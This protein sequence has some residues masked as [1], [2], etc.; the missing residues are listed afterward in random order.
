MKLSRFFTLLPS[1]NLFQ[2]PL[3]SSA[4]HS[5][6][7]ISASVIGPNTV[8]PSTPSLP[9]ALDSLQSHFFDT[10]A[11]TWPSAIDW[12]AAVISTLTAAALRTELRSSNNKAFNKQ[13]FERHFK[14]FLLS[15]DGQNARSIKLQAFDDILWVALNWVEGIRLLDELE[16]SPLR[17]SLSY[18]YDYWRARMLSR[19]REFWILAKNGWSTDLC[20]GGM[21]WSPWLEPYK[22]AIT[23]ELWISAS[24]SLFLYSPPPGSENHDAAY[25]DA[26]VQGYEWLRASH[27]TNNNGLYTDGFHISQLLVPDAPLPL[28][29][30]DRNEMVYTYNQGVLL[31][32][33][34]K[35][36]VRL[37]GSRD[38]AGRLAEPRRCLGG[39]L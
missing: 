34:R 31:S 26:A 25:L 2:P 33:L 35:G 36:W 19:A 15:F 1:T 11:R 17:D 10:A 16:A 22:N 38:R 13:A 21:N 14:E 6:A 32:G 18:N 39:G 27:M 28:E 37:T 7:P 29:C 12:T 9:F 24:S 30:D 20:G 23:N 3:T 5:A 8:Q 4:D